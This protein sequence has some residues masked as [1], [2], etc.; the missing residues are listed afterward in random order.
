MDYEDA[1]ELVLRHPGWIQCSACR[2]ARTVG[3]FFE[4]RGD[5]HD[6]NLPRRKCPGCNG[7]GHVLSLEFQEACRVL[8]R[9]LPPKPK[10]VV[11]FAANVIQTHSTALTAEEIKEEYERTFGHGPSRPLDYK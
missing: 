10:S 1:V 6:T 9:P 2:G 4:L 5:T 7:E 11:K 8:G 3:G